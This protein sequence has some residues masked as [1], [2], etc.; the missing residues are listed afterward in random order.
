MPTSSARWRARAP[1]NCASRANPKSAADPWRTLTG[2]HGGSQGE[3]PSQSGGRGSAPAPGVRSPPA[4]QLSA[5]AEMA[6]ASVGRGRSCRDSM[7][8]VST[9]S[10]FRPPAALAQDQLMVT[11]SAVERANATRTC[12]T[13]RCRMWRS[14][15]ASTSRRDGRTL[16][17]P[18]VK[19]ASRARS[20]RLGGTKACA[21]LSIKAPSNNH[22]MSCFS[23]Q[24]MRA[25]RERPESLFALQRG[26]S[27][28][29]GVASALFPGSRTGRSRRKIGR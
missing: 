2:T 23:A 3:E 13:R 24:R 4:L 6:E 9:R 5:R 17:A 11:T 26:S 16:R 28:A 10:G 12:M 7:S 1:M 22:S 20:I 29:G 14:P 15:R 21:S 25:M 19:S 8:D 18:I 27:A